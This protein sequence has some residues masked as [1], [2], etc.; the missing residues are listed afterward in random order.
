MQLISYKFFLFLKRSRVN[1]SLSG[2]IKISIN[3][4]KNDEERP[5]FER[6]I[7]RNKIVGLIDRR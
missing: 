7:F 4:N 2:P 5:I 3:F 6:D 1:N